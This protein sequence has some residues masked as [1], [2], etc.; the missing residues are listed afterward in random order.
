[1]IGGTATGQPFYLEPHDL[2]PGERAE[3]FS[4]VPAL[5]GSAVALS[6]VVWQPGTPEPRTILPAG[7]LAEWRERLCPAARGRAEAM[8]DAWAIVPQFPG[9]P[10]A[11]D[12]RPALMGVVNITPDSFYAESRRPG[13]DA[14][15]AL[16]ARMAQEGAA[17]LDVG[18]QSTRPGS[19]AIAEARECAASLPVIEA[20]ARTGATV[21]IDT[22]RPS[23]A[24]AA[25]QAGAKIVNDVSGLMPGHAIGERAGL[26][27][28]HMRGNPATMQRSPRSAR[29]IFSLYDWLEARI[30]GLVG[31]GIPKHRIAVDPGFGFGKAV[32]HNQAMIRHLPLF[33][34]LGVAIVIGMSRKGSLGYVAGAGQ[35][36]DRL[37]ASLA[38]ALTAAQ[39]GAAVLRVHDVAAT[40]QALQIAR[41]FR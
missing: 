7:E 41:F 31:E 8:L 35:A 17:I 19:A 14:A 16:G 33:T 9:I 20:L 1:V 22:V 32:N 39:A 10:R 37:P 28:G 36:A 4:G 25:V 27:I 18:S 3:R 29:G 23:V 21:S 13:L 34:G 12:Q 2:L 15:I 11:A 30:A 40:R 24:A 5:G 38:A 6:V 26:V